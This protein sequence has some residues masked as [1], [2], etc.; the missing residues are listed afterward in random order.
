MRKA[1]GL[2]AARM[3]GELASIKT[4]VE[5]GLVKK[6][7]EAVAELKGRMKGFEKVIEILEE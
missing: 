5:E 4:A 7:E 6:N 3:R 2:E 1:E